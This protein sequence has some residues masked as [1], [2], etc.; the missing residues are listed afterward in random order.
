MDS[1]INIDIWEGISFDLTELISPSK[2][3]ADLEAADI[4]L[5]FSL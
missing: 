5:L 4:A 1:N 2:F 3:L